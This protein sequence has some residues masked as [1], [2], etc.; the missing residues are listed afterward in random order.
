M[1]NIYDTPYAVQ[2]VQERLYFLSKNN[3]GITAVYPDGI[4]GDETIRSVKEF[5]AKQGIAQTGIVDYETFN[6]LI[7]EYED[8]LRKSS[9]PEK[10]RIFPR[11]LLNKAIN[12]GESF[13]VVSVIQSMILLLATADKEL[14]KVEITGVYDK[15]TE[16]A[17]N[18]IKKKFGLNGDSLIDKE[19]FSALTKL[20]ESFIND[21]T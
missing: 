6:L 19:F 13:T 3:Y 18:L 12:P 14:E 8:A 7:L 17:V 10:V 1:Y 4:Y 15:N 20:Y 9:P 21:D 2:N 16:S 11:L 5:Q